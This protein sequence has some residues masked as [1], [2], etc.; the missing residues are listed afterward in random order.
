MRG[1]REKDSLLTGTILSRCILLW[2]IILVGACHHPDKDNK[3]AGELFGKII[4]DT[5]IINRDSTDVWGA[6]CLSG[7]NRKVLI[8]KIFD[9]VFDGK[10][11]PYDYFTGEK[12]SPL[13]IREME[14]SGE[15]S[16][17]NISQLKFEERWIWDNE[18]VEMQKQLVSM[19]I[20]YEVYDNAGKSRGHKPIFKLVFRK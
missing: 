15:F 10:I 11:V 13:K 4:Y 7:L 2:L 12:V 20:A 1:S 19:T 8:D 16:R 6:E 17:E 18:K 14:K 3:P 9:S 5:T